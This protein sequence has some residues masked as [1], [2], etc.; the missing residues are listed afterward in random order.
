MYKLVHR[1]FANIVYP[2]LNTVS[3]TNTKMVNQRLS[4]ALHCRNNYLTIQ[5]STYNHLI[6]PDAPFKQFLE[7]HPLKN[8]LQNIN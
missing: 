4:C 3:V 8:Q 6:Y 7:Q 5:L 2:L 1:Y